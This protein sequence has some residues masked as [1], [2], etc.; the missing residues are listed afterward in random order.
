MELESLYDIDTIKEEDIINCLKENYNDTIKFLD[1]RKNID[2]SSFSNKFNSSLKRILTYHKYVAAKDSQLA[3]SCSVAC[4]V[5]LSNDYVSTINN[6]Q[7]RKY[8]NIHKCVAKEMYKL[9]CLHLNGQIEKYLNCYDN[10]L[11]FS[12]RA[13]IILDLFEENQEIHN[14]YWL[15]QLMCKTEK[16]ETSLYRMLKKREFRVLGKLN[17]LN[18]PVIMLHE[19]ENS[20]SVID[21]INKIGALNYYPN[22]META[23]ILSDKKFVRL[24]RILK[25]I[26]AF[27]RF[28]DDDRLKESYLTGKE[29]LNI[30][31]VSIAINCHNMRDITSLIF[32]EKENHI[33]FENLDKLIA[34]L[35]KKEREIVKNELDGI[36]TYG[37]LSDARKFKNEN[38]Y[39]KIIAIIKERNLPITYLPFD[40]L[41]DDSMNKL[42]E[43]KIIT[44]KQLEIIN[45][46][47]KI[48][49]PILEESM[50]ALD[51]LV[52][53]PKPNSL[54][55][56][57]IPLEN[58]K[59]SELSL[60]ELNIIRLY[61]YKK[62]A[63]NQIYGYNVSLFKYSD[64]NTAGFHAKDNEIVISN[65]KDT[66]VY[67]MIKTINH[68]INHAIQNKNMEEMNVDKD[69]D[70][71]EYY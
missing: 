59:R 39:R 55:K 34:S 71:L 37:Y 33:N 70:N 11:S 48:T 8:K 65:G 1:T 15:K 57:L 4:Y 3:S 30:A 52:Y 46:M 32:P 22:K 43:D 61:A 67:E 60:E 41:D 13:E 7:N 18:N 17:L 64:F 20:T 14:P 44:N 31:L 27:D 5:S 36:I 58:K 56:A 62:L 45:S 68:E 51:S 66:S 25:R 16:E 2:Y 23:W 63:D 21:V 9:E 38:E 54:E 40:D 19:L 49:F 12:Q 42:V 26:K 47:R 53:E 29:E 35:E 28:G 24:K 50:K 6:I 69:E 10:V